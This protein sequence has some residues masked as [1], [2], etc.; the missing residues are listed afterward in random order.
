MEDDTIESAFVVDEDKARSLQIGMHRRDGGRKVLTV[1]Y[2]SS[3]Q[4][5][6]V[7]YKMVKL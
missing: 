4:T 5:L 3:F 2:R 7:A 6:N 1:L